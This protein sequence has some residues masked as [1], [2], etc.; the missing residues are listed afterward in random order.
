MS[1]QTKC[2]L[3]EP[4]PPEAALY[5]WTIDQII[6]DLNRAEPKAIPRA[7][8]WMRQTGSSVLLNWG[9]HDDVWECSWITGG[10]RYTGESENMTAAI[11]GS[12][13]KVKHRETPYYV[14]DKHGNRLRH[15]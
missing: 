3:H 1:E 11:V 12:L 8:E 4:R 14:T 6:E 5:L 2:N 15:G 9:E 10:K 13:L 7:L